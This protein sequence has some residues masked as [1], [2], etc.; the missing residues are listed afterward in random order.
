M[1]WSAEQGAP[2]RSGQDLGGVPRISFYCDSDCILACCVRAH[3]TVLDVQRAHL[4]R[5]CGPFLA[6]QAHSKS[7]NEAILG[8]PPRD[9]LF[10]VLLGY[11]DAPKRGDGTQIELQPCPNRT[12]SCHGYE[13]EGSLSKKDDLTMRYYG[14]IALFVMALV[15]FAFPRVSQATFY[16]WQDAQGNTHFTDDL[17]RVP[18][19]QRERVEVQDLPEYPVNVA[20]AAPPPS[21]APTQDPSEPVDNYKE[22]QKKVTEEKEKW[23]LQLEQD[24]DRLVELNKVI[25]RAT[26]A[27]RKNEFQRE[28]VAVKDRID[29]SQQVL[30]ETL[31]PMEHEC[32]TLRYWQ[33]EE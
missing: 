33:D 16:S 8:Q 17:T 32:E 13:N 23:T 28:R 15:T 3:K 14:I 10:V 6:Y 18:P 7:R 9:S 2:R 22:C 29:K 20:P 31:P 26:S 21:D 27:R 19:S 1:D 4:R 5:F 12:I 11:T 24:E 25:H 30:L